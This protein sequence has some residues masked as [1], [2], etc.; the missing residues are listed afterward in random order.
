LPSIAGQ[1][2]LPLDRPVMVTGQGRE[3]LWEILRRTMQL[4]LEEYAEGRGQ[5]DT[6]LSPLFAAMLTHIRH[7]VAADRQCRPVQVRC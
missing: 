3:A 4:I 7:L 5:A 6:I 2:T 1:T